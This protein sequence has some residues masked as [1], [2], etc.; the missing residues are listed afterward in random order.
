MTTYDSTSG[1]HA[2]NIDPSKDYVPEQ[3]GPAHDPN[4]MMYCC[5]GVGPGGRT[6]NIE[7]NEKPMLDRIPLYLAENI[8]CDQDNN[9]GLLA[10]HSKHY[11]GIYTETHHVSE[12]WP[13]IKTVGGEGAYDRGDYSY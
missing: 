5:Y 13:E 2:Y 10:E 3:W 12:N 7:N 1:T 6:S 9:M 8:E 11:Q 4:C